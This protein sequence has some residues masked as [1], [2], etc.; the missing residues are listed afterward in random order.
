MKPRLGG[1][2]TAWEKS[3]GIG[4]RS[5]LF[6]SLMRALVVWCGL[7]FVFA[8]EGSAK[9]EALSSETRSK[10]VQSPV[11]SMPTAPIRPAPAVAAEPEGVVRYS[12]SI[13]IADLAA[14]SLG[15][16]AAVAPELW[17]PALGTYFLGAPV[18]HLAHG[19][20]R[21]AFGSLGLRVALPLTAG[22]IA[23]SI[24]TRDCSWESEEEYDRTCKS[25]VTWAVTG[26]EEG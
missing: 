17:I 22:A 9:A 18:I 23:A 10:V 15:A 6:V 14:L 26:V 19:S 20:A 4:A 16:A 25:G 1:L 12:A 21:K 2:R 3:K 13:V 24:G 11:R 5:L 7:G 8:R